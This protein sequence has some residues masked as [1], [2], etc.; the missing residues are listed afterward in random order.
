LATAQRTKLLRKSHLK[1]VNVDTTV[2]EKAIAFP[3]DARLYEKMRRRL[4]REVEQRGIKL[5]QSYRRLGKRALQKQS[6]YAHAR[7]IEV[8]LLSWT[9]RRPC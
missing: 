6:A 1:R 9:A 4:D 2:Q 8:V 7:Q 3:T 5:R